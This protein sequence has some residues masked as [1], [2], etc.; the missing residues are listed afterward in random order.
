M[1]T[2]KIISKHNQILFPYSKGLVNN[3][4]HNIVNTT[5]QCFAQVEEFTKYFLDPKNQEKI[6]SNKNKYKLSIAFIEILNNLW[7]N[8]NLKPYS[9]C[10]LE[11]KI[12]EINSKFKIEES[13]FKGLICFLLDKM[14][15]ELNEIY[16]LKKLN[17][18]N[19]NIIENIDDYNLE[20]DFKNFSYNFEKTHNSIISNIFYGIYHFEIECSKCKNI[21]SGF[22]PYNLLS[23]SLVEVKELINKKGKLVDLYDCLEYF[24][25]TKELNRE[26]QMICQ[27]CMD[28]KNGLVNI[29][30]ITFPNILIINLQRK[31]K[32]QYDIKLKIEEYLINFGNYNYELI[33]I[34]KNLGFNNGACHNYI[35]FCKS[36]SNKKWYI[37]SDELVKPSSI[38][39]AISTGVSNILIYS[40]QKD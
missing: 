25:K 27:K 32:Q 38:E 34:I 23:F 4:S 36:F 19:Q 21:K 22:N 39:E 20:L 8:N 12:N 17:N 35:A 5:L 3:G 14:N 6:L 29:K 11:K 13:D 26:K 37:Y 7:L 40:L 28:L 16:D 15:N 18:K 30:I 24:E 2:S 33:G 1:N 31:N 10:Y 9:T